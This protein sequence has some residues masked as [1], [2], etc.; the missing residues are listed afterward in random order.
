MYIY[1]YIYIYI[2]VYIYIYYDKIARIFSL[3]CPASGKGIFTVGVL[4]SQ[5]WSK[6]N[7]GLMPP[8]ALKMLKLTTPAWAYSYCYPLVIEHSYGK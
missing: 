8:A 7:W 6:N 2:Y 3:F 4:D 5:T 1:I